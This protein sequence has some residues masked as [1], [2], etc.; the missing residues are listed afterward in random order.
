VSVVTG[1]AQFHGQLLIAHEEARRDGRCGPILDRLFRLAVETGKRA[2]TETA[3]GHGHASVGSV[4][5]T[6]V[7]GR[8]GG[9]Q[10]R[11]IAVIGAG[12]MGGLT[13]RS[14]VDRGAQRS[15]VVNRTGERAAELAAACGS[16]G[17]GIPFEQL[18]DEL[19]VCDAVIS[20]TNAPHVV[21]TRDRLEGI[22]ARRDGRELVLVDL[23][24][25][26]DL[27]A[28]CGELAGVHMFDL[29]DLER[30]V[31]ETLEVRGDAIDEVAALADEATD[32]FVRWLRSLNA[33]DAIR[34]LR[35]RAERERRAELERFLA[36][37]AHLAAEDIE[38]IDRLTRTIVNRVLHTPTVKLREAAERS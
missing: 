2:R 32:T 21:L 8:I 11:R 26:R 1:E 6:L 10:D 33:T 27:D 5:A 3:I 4:A 36:R 9:L 34:E 38:R 35:E 25:P 13:A 23:A 17:D 29:D 30:V 12:K 19:V 28:A 14:L 22:M 37:H 18:D 20:A 24:V 16:T 7:E 31:A 15:D